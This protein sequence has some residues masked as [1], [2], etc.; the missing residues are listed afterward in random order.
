MFL[1]KITMDLYHLSC[2]YYTLNMISSHA[3]KYKVGP[4][5]TF[6]QPLRPQAFIM[7][8]NQ[9]E[10]QPSVIRLGGFHTIISYLGSLGHLINGLELQEF[11]EVIYA[12]NSMVYM[13]SGKA[14]SPAIRGHLLVD[15]ALTALIA[16]LAL[17]INK[18]KIFV[19]GES[20]SGP[21]TP[22]EK[23]MVLCKNVIAEI[24]FFDECK[25]TIY[26][27]YVFNSFV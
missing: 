15:V 20:L 21:T 23:G 2:I 17:D 22:A 9:P 14:G 12:P 27:K 24:V 11:L 4:I 25:R 8:E 5:V 18:A 16:L 1:P 26:C 13:L 10:I 3:I 19:F 7:I 6:D